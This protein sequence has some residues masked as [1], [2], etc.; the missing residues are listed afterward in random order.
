MSQLIRV[1]DQGGVSVLTMTAGANALDEN[2]IAAMRQELSALNAA[3]A[4]ALVLASQ[5]PRVFCPGLDLKKLDGAG[6]ETVRAVME[7]FLALLREI[8][9]YPGPAIA[10]V[11]GHAIAGGCLL[12]M[13]CDRRVMARSG[14]RLGLSEV[15]LGIPVPAGAVAMLLALYPTRSV[16]QLVLEGDGYGGERALELGLVERLADAPEVLPEAVRLARHLAS[17]PSKAFRLAKSYMRAFLA[18]TMGQR[19][20]QELEAFLD[21]WFGPDTQDRLAVLVAEMSR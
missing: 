16:E 11:S 6:R 3:G 13:A 15:N 8:V 19:D 2:L 17:R 4:P 12:A 20:A 7:A 1:E 10:A 21:C 9:S 5:H 14:A 18:E